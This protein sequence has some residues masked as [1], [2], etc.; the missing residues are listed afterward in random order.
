VGCHIC[1]FA[2]AEDI[3]NED[4]KRA[5]S[6]ILLKA[7]SSNSNE[8][9]GHLFRLLL[10]Q[11]FGNKIT[12]VILRC[13]A[14]AIISS[15]VLSIVFFASYDMFIFTIATKMYIRVYIMYFL[16]VSILAGLVSFLIV[17]HLLLEEYNIFAQI[18][19]SILLPAAI[20]CM[21]HY[22]I[23][24]FRFNWDIVHSSSIILRDIF[25][26]T[27]MTGLFISSYTLPLM[28]LIF[29][30]SIPLTKMIALGTT[31]LDVENKPL[32]SV[33]LISATIFSLPYTIFFS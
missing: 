28:F 23:A 10:R 26:R 25:G 11:V 32:K 21:M 18:L 33:G 14:V 15:I 13:F 31:F 24:K 6:S 22:A 8:Q 30:V 1:F 2:K 27:A 12:T 29:S 3:V 7:R 16:P 5:I 19:L 4:T 17:R 9:I 20:F